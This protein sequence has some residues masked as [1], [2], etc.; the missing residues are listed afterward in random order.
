MGKKRERSRV[1]SNKTPVFEASIKDIRTY[2]T[3]V[4]REI[5]KSEPASATT[6]TPYSTPVITP[7]AFIKKENSA[8]EKVKKTIKWSD[9]DEQDN[10]DNSDDLNISNA[11]IT[12]RKPQLFKEVISKLDELMDQ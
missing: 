9:F 4:K 11:T 5:I 12:T 3:P 10:E 6:S 7:D 1:S 8:R 2:F